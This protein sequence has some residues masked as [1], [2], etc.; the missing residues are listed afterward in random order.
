MTREASTAYWA[1][2]AAWTAIATAGP[3]RAALLGAPEQ[4]QIG[5][6]PANSP[7]ADDIQW[8]H[9]VILFRVPGRASGAN[10]GCGFGATAARSTPSAAA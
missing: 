4:G 10:Q 8:L 6:L 1:G 3:A 5:F 7:V 2:A 9:N